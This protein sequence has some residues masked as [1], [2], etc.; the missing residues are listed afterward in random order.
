MNTVSVLLGPIHVPTNQ[1]LGKIKALDAWVHGLN[2]MSTGRQKHLKSSV[3]TKPPCMSQK[4]CRVADQPYK[5]TYMHMYM[6]HACNLTYVHAYRI[7]I[8]ACKQMDRKSDSL[9]AIGSGW[10]D[11]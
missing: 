1:P 7:I 8:H 11:R 6:I 4:P 9:M 5:H 10:P 2:P 3:E